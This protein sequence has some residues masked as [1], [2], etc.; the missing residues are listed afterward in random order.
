MEIHHIS[1]SVFGSN[2]ISSHRWTLTLEANLE[3]LHVFLR[4]YVE[5]VIYETKPS[6][7]AAINSTTTDSQ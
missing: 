3:I 2:C 5:P 1:L 4:G 7:S 6:N